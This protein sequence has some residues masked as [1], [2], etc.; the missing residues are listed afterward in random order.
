MNNII[1]LLNWKQYC[2][3]LVITY[4]DK[5]TIVDIFDFNDDKFYLNELNVKKYENK[6]I[7]LFNGD[8]NFPPPLKEY[9]YE[10]DPK[11]NGLPPNDYEMKPYKEKIDNRIIDYIEKNNIKII[12]Y[13]S[14]IFH[15]NVIMIPLGIS[16]QININNNIINTN[17][18][19]TILCYANFGI[20]CDRWFGNIRKELYATMTHLGFITNENVVLDDNCRK[21]NNNYDNY[22]Y[23]LKLSKFSLCPPGCGID[24]YRVYDSILCGCIPIC[25][26]YE[27]FYKNFD[28]NIPILFINNYDELN[29]DLL[30]NNYERLNNKFSM[31]AFSIDNYYK[32]LL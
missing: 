30:I 11:Y 7:I 25:L 20:P 14:S 32:L 12:C 8:V 26:K 17:Y 2:K 9:T 3:Q 1:T 19:K 16:W 29:E 28:E 31:N 22:F 10:F 18:N 13:S 27:E 5:Y 23:K 15:K 24:S 21:N 4:P 6:H